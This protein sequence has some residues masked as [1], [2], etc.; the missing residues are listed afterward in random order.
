MYVACVLTNQC[1]TIYAHRESLLGRWTSMADDWYSARSNASGL[2]QHKD[3]EGRT[4]GC[5]ASFPLFLTNYLK[6]PFRSFPS[7]EV[8]TAIASKRLISCTFMT[9]YVSP[10]PLRH[11]FFH[12]L[13]SP[14]TVR[15]YLK[16]TFK[17]VS[18]DRN[19]SLLT[20]TW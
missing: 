2:K 13:L 3:L 1:N 9:K 15:Y 8:Y 7:S 18:T 20:D 5:A 6:S 10:S 12:S 16:T 17:S 19:R 4:T 11:K 14:N